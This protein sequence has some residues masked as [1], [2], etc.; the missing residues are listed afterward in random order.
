MDI[1]FFSKNGKLF[2]IVDATIPL[3]NI[4]YQY[5][6]GVYEAIRVRNKI[7]YFT[8]QHVGRLLQSARLIGLEHIYTF[9]EIDS[10]I[11]EVIQGNNAQNC[12]LKILLIGGKNTENAL[13][14]ILPLAPL[15]PD[16]KIYSN[17]VTVE[18][19]QYERFLPNAK[20]L[21]MLQSYMH[22][23]KASG[24]GHYDALFLDDKNNVLEGSRT[25]FFVIK[26][27][28]L[29]TPLKE[30]ILEGVTRQTVIAAAK[31]NGFIVEERM[32]NI[33]EL[34]NF[35]G[36]FL[37]C[38]SAKII[39]LIQ[40]DNFKFNEIPEKLKELMHTYIKFL[41]ESKGLFTESE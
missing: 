17:G 30:K 34:G 28:T 9:P 22:Y 18:T 4:A 7:A 35:D 31:K 39:P 40:I 24:K 2:P 21:N 33:N 3:E 25:N 16:K 8:K 1:Q 11:Q 38:T 20:T 27:K 15:F 32:I 37:T 14:F 10:Y 41:E 23:T 6:F 36:A 13:L 26:D 19:V 29:I 12:S 5:G